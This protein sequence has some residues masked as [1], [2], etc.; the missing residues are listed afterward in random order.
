MHFSFSKLFLLLISLLIAFTSCKKESGQHDPVPKLEFVSVTPS[1]IIEFQQTLEFTVYYEDGDGDLGENLADVKNLFL[2]DNRNN[3]RYEYRLQQLGPLGSSYPIKGR[4]KILL[5]G[6]AIT[7]N[8][9]QQNAIFSIY[10]ID[11]SGHQS[12]TVTSSTIII[13]KP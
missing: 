2:T 10:A 9:T 5:N 12:N 6:V 4:F 3:V 11:R 13:H 1:D 8:S 7:D